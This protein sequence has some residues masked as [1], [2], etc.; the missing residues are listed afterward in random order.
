[1]PAAT[2]NGLTIGGAAN[3]IMYV[4]NVKSITQ[5]PLTGGMGVMLFTAVAVLLAAGAGTFYLWSRN[6]RR[7]LNA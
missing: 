6:V 2:G 7:T 5:L 4:K 3:Q 1:M